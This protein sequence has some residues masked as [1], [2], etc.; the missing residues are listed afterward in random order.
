MEKPSAVIEIT[1]SAIKLVTG[2]VVDDKPA[3]IY[4]RSIPASEF[5]K[6]GEIIDYGGLTNA[7][8]SFKQISDPEARLRLS[9]TDATIIF[10]AIGFEIFQ[11]DKITNVVSTSSLV[12]HLDIQNAIS[13]VQ[14]ETV[15]NGSDILD[16]IPAAFLLEGNRQFIAPPIG[17]KSSSIAIRAYVHTLPRRLISD[18]TRV[19]E[20]AGIHVKRSV[21]SSYAFTEA[22]KRET[23]IKPNYILVDMGEDITTFTLVGSHFPINSR[24]MFYGNIT[25]RERVATEFNIDKLKAKE[26]LDCYGYST[27]KNDFYPNIVEVET[28]DGGHY[29]YTEKDLRNVISNFMEEYFKSFDVALQT[30]LGD[31]PDDVK[32]TLPL[33]FT[34]EL[35]KLLGFDRFA[36]SR[37]S[38]YASIEFYSPKHIGLRDASLGAITGALYLSSGYRGSLSDQRAKVSQVS[39]ENPSKK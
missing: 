22:I 26:L 21:V 7:I 34:G 27:T 39:R 37:Y 19:V 17:E 24:Y 15:S 3:V 23:D 29:G 25:L 33:V 10:P 9:I 35:S 4:T 28:E 11:S 31:Y 12:Q 32:K 2:F 30:L 13:L 16:I 5:V 8:A 1:S 14:K 6:N 20:S 38:D 36:K 18:Y